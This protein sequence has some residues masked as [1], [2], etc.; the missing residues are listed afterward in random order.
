LRASLS[1]RWSLGPLVALVGLLAPPVATA[2]GCPSSDDAYTGNC[3]PWF[4]VPSW[5]DAGGWND[6]SQYSTI[7]LADVNGDGRDELIG[8]SDAGVQVYRFDTTVGQ[9]RPQVDGN[10]VP[11]LL[12]DFAS[13]LPSDESDPFNPNQPQ[14]YSTIQA[15]DVDGRAGAEILGRFWDGMRVY[16]YTPPQGGGIDGGSW[17]GIGALGP[18]SDAD[19]YGDPS[20]YSTIQVAQFENY[21]PPVLFARR[22]GGGPDDDM[23][24]Y[25][26]WQNGA[27]SAVPGLGVSE[28][29]TGQ[30]CGHPSC[31]LDLKTGNLVGG[32]YDP[33]AT[34][35]LIVR[36]PQYGF[37]AWGGPA[38]RG[39]SEGFGGPV[40]DEAF[41]DAPSTRDCPF[42]SSGV[43]GPGSG[44]C[45]G[46]SPSYYETWQAADVNGL[47]GE[48]L[49]VRASDGLRL[50][51]GGY[52][53]TTGPTLTALA[54]AP[55]DMPA[56][57]WGSIRTGNID[58]KGG[59]E[60]LFLD[61]NGNGLQ[62]YSYDPAAKAWNQLQPSTPLALG[63]DPWLSDPA[64]YSTI[65]TGD[66][67]GD[68]RDDVI[69]RGPYGIRTWFYDRRGTGGWE[70]YLADGPFPSAVDRC[71]CYPAFSG[72]QA[73][74]YG[75]L[76]AAYRAALNRSGTI[77]DVWTQ[78]NAPATDFSDTLLPDLEGPAIGN[79]SNRTSLEP[80]QYGSCTPPQGSS[81][82]TQDDWTAVVNQILAEA[83][84]ADQVLGFF[85]NLTARNNDLFLVE[86]AEMGSLASTLSLEAAAGTTTQFDALPFVSG[87]LG[88]AASIAGGFPGGSEFSAALWVASE[89]VS[90]IPQTSP[91]V[92]DGGFSSSLDG[93][94]DRFAKIVSETQTGVDVM[95]QQ[96]RQDA[97]L[98]ALVSQLRTTGGMPWADQNL[99][100]IGIRSAANQGFV[101]WVYKTL[102]P[103]LYDRYVVNGCR[104]YT[105]Y[106]MAGSNWTISPFTKFSC[107]DPPTQ[108]PGVQAQDEQTF[109]SIGQP[110]SPDNYPCFFPA[111]FQG[112]CAYDRVP[113]IETKNADPSYLLS[114]QIWG[115][116]SYSP[117][118]DCAYQPG[119]PETA[120]DFGC[121]AGVDVH[122]SV[123]NN[124]WGFTSFS[125]SPDFADGWSCFSR[126]GCD[127]SA[128]QARSQAPIRLAR[129]RQGRRRAVRGRARLQAEV[130]TLRGM[131]LAGA[132]V[133]V[134]RVL[135]EPG[136]GELT[137]PRR[138]ARPLRLRLRRAGAGRFVAA[139]EGRR[140][141]R[142]AIQRGPRGLASLT[143]S[144]GRVFHTPRAC[145]ALPASVARRMPPLWLHSRVVIGDGRARVRVPMSHHVRCA[146]D[147]RGNVNRLE[148]VRYRR[149]P[150]RSG[151]ALTV[152]GP[153]RVQAGTTARYVARV[154][155][156]RRDGGR[157]ASSLWGVTVNAGARTTQIRE[158]R[159]GR[160]RTVAFSV[161][162]PPTARG[163]FCAQA[164]ATAPGARAARA[165]VCARVQAARPPRVTG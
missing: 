24:A 25:Y 87:G 113:G 63:S 126:G 163:R 136:H 107:I 122:T 93:L 59:A 152:R 54:G 89:V 105:N 147:A 86:Q 164:I 149:H 124:T 71:K 73:A 145:H 39:D 114:R 20:L 58:G 75:A 62:A 111:S 8:R 91:T 27:W 33:N 49:L 101:I 144:S 92:T 156:R 95:S 84:S 26:T 15:A 102:M 46:S 112:A 130:G 119:K 68:G 129:P 55:S 160:M 134:N 65:Q 138:A 154:R 19:G 142:V 151:L 9:W 162:V 61:G 1:L 3:G 42:S 143:L 158:L 165:G 100:T 153:R 44:D 128:A 70:R 115:E 21:E 67:D 127:S 10:G 69:A 11:Q 45:V 150:L 50:V 88:I 38:V 77:R 74:A 108:V 18:F 57:M 116:P 43:T 159:R 22:N 161:R 52:E 135:F 32:D 36:T 5:T 35:G 109:I 79:C 118:R 29:F 17:S 82:F 80:P 131:R 90:M 48:E 16:K 23:L 110:N 56:G 83:Y 148:H 13:F 64:Y 98:V 37:Y 123:G 140:R 146:R 120:W 31:Y 96:V 94:K 139:S 103:T 121:W 157:M 97:G 85:D 155:N 117:T 76:N 133:R 30:D 7:Q 78:E 137:H 14:F 40:Y 41:A 51:F 104:D 81:G 4:A 132:T 12:S 141:L 99:D 125:G 28:L 60:V 66:V 53:R 2:D 72:G 47:P 6:P 34:D 106:K